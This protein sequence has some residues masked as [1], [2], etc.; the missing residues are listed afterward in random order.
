MKTILLLVEDDD[1]KASAVV[2]RITREGIGLVRVTTMVSA[3]RA[4]REG[5]QLEGA[6]GGPYPVGAVLTDWAFPFRDGDYVRDHAGQRVYDEA[7]RAGLPVAVFSGREEPVPG[8][9]PWINSTDYQALTDWL[10]QVKTTLG[11]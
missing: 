1:H 11:S 3:V 5:A 8:V 9:Q 10:G 4:I 7:T 6:K 2:R